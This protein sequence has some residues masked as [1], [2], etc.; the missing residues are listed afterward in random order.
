MFW[1]IGAYIL[2]INLYSFI[3]RCRYFF[4]AFDKCSKLSTSKKETSFSEYSSRNI[5]M[6]EHI[7]F[8]LKIAASNTANENPSFR[9][10]MA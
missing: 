7:M 1:R 2:L 4:Y 6:S 10:G 9:L 8:F 5:G 3:I